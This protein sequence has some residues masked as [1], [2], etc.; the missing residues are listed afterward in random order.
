MEGKRLAPRGALR[1]KKLALLV[2]ASVLAGCATVQPPAPPPPPAVAA[3]AAPA[4]PRTFS[5]V[6]E[7]VVDAWAE[8]LRTDRELYK[9]TQH[10]LRRGERFLP[11]L[12]RI[13]ADSGVPGSLALLPAVESGFEPRARGRSGELGLWQLRAATARRCGLVVNARRDD[14][15][16]LEPSTLCAASFL[17]F[18]HARYRDWPLALAAYNAG[19]NRVDRALARD[20][21]ASFWQLARQNR[22]PRVSREYVPRF[23][24]LVRVVEEPRGC[25]PAQLAERRG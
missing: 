21:G 25:P 14:R 4:P 2:G 9:D 1:P 20:P 7:P 12:R 11:E 19:Q 10:S 22:L 8:R 13:L 16:K 3:P 15:T 6:E 24:A 17:R 23:L 5:C 18:L